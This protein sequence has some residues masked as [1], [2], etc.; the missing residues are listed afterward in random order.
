[1]ARPIASQAMDDL[2]R[3]SVLVIDTAGLSLSTGLASSRRE[4]SYPKQKVEEFLTAKWLDNFVAEL[5]G[6]ILSEIARGARPSIRSH[7]ACVLYHSG[8]WFMQQ[9]WW[10]M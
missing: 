10:T 1:M 8:A 5:L 4:I 3:L 9:R 6:P 2:V 7:K